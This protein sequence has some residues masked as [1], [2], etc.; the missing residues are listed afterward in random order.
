[1]NKNELKYWVGFS[2]VP[3]IGRIRFSQL[4]NYFENLENA[5][6]AEPADLKRAGLD[7]GTVNSII[8]RRPEICVDREMERLDSFGAMAITR[9]DEVYPARLKEIYDHPPLIYVKGEIKA[10]DER[11]LAVVGTRRASMYGRQI[12]EDFTA[13]LAR[14][15]VTIIS[16][17]ARGIDSVAHRAALDAGGRS[18]AVFGCGLDVIYP[19]ENAGLA[20]R[21]VEQGALISEY[22]LG[23]R[24]R[25]DRFPRRNRIMS[26]MSLGVLV[27][28]AGKNSGAMITA[29][30]ALEYNREVFAVPGNILS[31]VSAGTNRLIQEGAK[32]VSSY[33]DILEELNLGGVTRQLE[34]KEIIPTS[35][36]EAVLLKHLGAEPLHIN[37]VCRNSGLSISEVSSTLAMMEIRGLVRQMGPMSFILARKNS[38]L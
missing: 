37:E 34:M 32:L 6:R 33:E 31:P 7:V 9:Y 1:M 8:A 24:P 15:G 22:P 23:I 5:W 27:I 12:T 28:E 30:L 18:I 17:L 21:M 36:K 20:R 16:G 19:A 25:P 11:C 4:E 3:G 2:L 29:N 13:D 38:G 35:G 10:E 26:G 14:S